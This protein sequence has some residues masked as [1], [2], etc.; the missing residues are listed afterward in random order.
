[1]C[2]GRWG[3]TE[4]HQQ[5]NVA[6]I[7]ARFS[8]N[9]AGSGTTRV[10]HVYSTWKRK[11]L[12]SWNIPKRF[13]HP[14]KTPLN[15]LLPLRTDR[16]LIFVLGFFVCL[17]KWSFEWRFL[18]LFGWFVIFHSIKIV[19]SLCSCHLPFVLFLFLPR[20]DFGWFFFLMCSWCEFILAMHLMSLASVTS[21]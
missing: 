21:G 1:M 17:F 16:I 12:G 20:L 15:F 11:F 3:W 5:L 6:S 8:F 18:F 14:K 2:D 9:L 7:P 13:L 4:E 10:S 19:T